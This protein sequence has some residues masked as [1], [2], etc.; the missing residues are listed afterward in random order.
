M[1]LECTC[2]KKNKSHGL[3]GDFDIDSDVKLLIVPDAGSN[4]VKEHVRL[5]DEGI[6]CLWQK[7]ISR[8]L[9]CYS[10]A[11]DLKTSG[12]LLRLVLY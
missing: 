2:T 8:I 10:M 12:L 9:D 6:D 11:V 7:M 1:I 5:H 3:D 4:D